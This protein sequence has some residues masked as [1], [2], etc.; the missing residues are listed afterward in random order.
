MIGDRGLLL[1]AAGRGPL[2]LGAGHGNERHNSE[3]G[4]DNGSV[5]H[6]TPPC[7][8]EWGTRSRA[9]PF[10]AD[11]E[12]ASTSNVRYGSVSLLGDAAERGQII[13]PLDWQRR[14][15]AVVAVLAGGDH[16]A[17]PPTTPA[18]ARDSAGPLAV[19]VQRRISQRSAE[20]S[21]P[22]FQHM[23]LALDLVEA[24]PELTHFATHARLRARASVWHPVR[25]R[26]AW[27]G[28]I[29]GG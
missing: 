9:W 8:G 7:V 27:S 1:M 13:L 2:G 4:E 29:A 11:D 3:S 28:R 5:N 16:V 17:P 6:A 14:L 10:N 12:G 26:G 25:R 15:L 18:L 19:G 24:A 21:Q 20:A 22:L 23:D